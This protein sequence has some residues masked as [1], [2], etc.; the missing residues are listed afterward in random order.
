[1]KENYQAPSIELT[2]ISNEDVISTSLSVELPWLP[3][4]EEI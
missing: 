1:M 3:L 2:L 4:E